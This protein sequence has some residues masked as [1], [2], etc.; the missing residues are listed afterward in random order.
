MR[1][2]SNPEKPLLKNESYGMVQA[3]DILRALIS[4]RKMAFTT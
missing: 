3:E 2:I 1:L 4:T